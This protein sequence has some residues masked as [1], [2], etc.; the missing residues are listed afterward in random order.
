L[1]PSAKIAVSSIGSVVM[2]SVRRWMFVPVDVHR[3]RR[4]RRGGATPG[5]S[6][7]AG[8]APAGCS[9][10][11]VAEEGNLLPVQLQLTPPL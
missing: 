3:G 6:G 9:A 4:G 11:A 7:S 8:S 1:E 10:A 5:A 2:V